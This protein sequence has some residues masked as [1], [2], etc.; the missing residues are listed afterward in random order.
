MVQ[1]L[2]ASGENVLV[3]LP[4]RYL[5]AVVP[6]SSRSKGVKVT[7]LFGVCT[8]SKAYSSRRFPSSAPPPQCGSIVFYNFCFAARE[9]SATASSSV[10]VVGV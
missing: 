5:R 7:A 4:E 3:V 9:L 1:L 10:E 2:E 8:N 6:N